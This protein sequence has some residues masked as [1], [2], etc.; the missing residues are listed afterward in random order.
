MGIGRASLEG[1]FYMAKHGVDFHHSLTIGRQQVTVGLDTLKSILT[2]YD[3]NKEYSGKNIYAEELFQFFG[4]DVVDSI[5]YSDYENATILHDMNLPI[6]EEYKEKYSC[7]WDGGSL[8]HVFNYPVAIKNCM[9]MVKIN[10]HIILHTPANNLCG[11]GFYQF[12][13]ELFFSLFHKSNGFSETRIYMQDDIQNWFEVKS[14]LVLKQRISF[15]CAR[16]TEALLLVVSKKTAQVPLKL[17][18]QQS[19]YIDIWN[20]ESGET[21]PSLERSNGVT[22]VNLIKFLYRLFIPKIIR[23]AILGVRRKA[24]YKKHLREYC[25]P[26]ENFTS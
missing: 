12:S 8:E 25:I 22:K 17:T 20:Q 19:D 14:P 4:A 26:V 15:C 18:V 1:M 13:P 7:V 10:G 2:K 3:S 23:T 11:H 5:D 21:N 24:R 16:E 6:S 9:E